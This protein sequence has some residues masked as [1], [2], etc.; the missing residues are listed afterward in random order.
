VELD[1][2]FAITDR[3]MVMNC[4]AIT[5]IVETAQTNAREIGL[6]MTQQQVQQAQSLEALA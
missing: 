3:I 5:G 1:E 2:I 6:L 4:G